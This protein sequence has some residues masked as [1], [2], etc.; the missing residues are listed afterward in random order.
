[1]QGC[2]VRHD[3]MLPHG[4]RFFLRLIRPF[5]SCGRCGVPVRFAVGILVPEGLGSF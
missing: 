1:M 4:G 2:R 5:N 3:L